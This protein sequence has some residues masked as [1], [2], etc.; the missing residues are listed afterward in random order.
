MIENATS[1]DDLIEAWELSVDKDAKALN[2]LYE[3]AKSLGPAHENSFSF[4]VQ[5]PLELVATDFN[6]IPEP[7][8]SRNARGIPKAEA[9]LML[10][11]NKRSDYLKFNILAINH[12]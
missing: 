7:I 2:R 5:V 9:S 8:L 10:Y 12:A 1:S 3:K 6:K 11:D 4:N